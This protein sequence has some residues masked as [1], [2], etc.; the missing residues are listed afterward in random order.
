MAV[1]LYLQASEGGGPRNEPRSPAYSEELER[2][3]ILRAFVSSVLVY[4]GT[5]IAIGDM[6]L[7]DGT[8]SPHQ[9]RYLR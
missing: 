1:S 8:G 9:S 4:N 7:I 2:A 5:D 3:T 6:L